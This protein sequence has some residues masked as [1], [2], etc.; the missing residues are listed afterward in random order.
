MIRLLV[1]W[2]LPRHNIRAEGLRRVR[3]LGSR[4]SVAAHKLSRCSE[5]QVQDIVE[6]EHL[7]V[8]TWPG[9]NPYGRRRNLSRDHPRHFAWNS[10]EKNAGHSSAVKCSGISH[11]LLDL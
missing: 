5:S 4:I 1:R 2:I 10:L 9:A 3:D 6:D 11:E 8:A 7:A